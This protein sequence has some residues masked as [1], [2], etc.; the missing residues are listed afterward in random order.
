VRWPNRKIIMNEKSYP[1]CVSNFI[2]EYRALVV[3]LGPEGDDEQLRVLLD[4]DS[5]WS[6]RGSAT[7][8]VLAR[9]YGTFVLANALA[10]AEALGIEDGK[11]GL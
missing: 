5:A 3:S 11:T 4:K 1:D 8:V 7:L 9:E 10:L 6:A 2:D